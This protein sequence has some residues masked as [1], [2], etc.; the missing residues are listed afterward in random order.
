MHLK[1]Y[2]QNFEDSLS[3]GKSGNLMV[4]HGLADSFVNKIPFLFDYLSD[5]EKTRAERFRLYSDYN[6]Y[7]SVH[8][9]LRIELSK[10]LGVKARSLKILL[11]DIGKPYMADSNI[12]FNLSRTKN[13]FAFAIG[14]DNHFLGIDIE[15][16]KPEIDYKSIAINYFSVDEQKV[17]FSLKNASDQNRTFFEIWTRKEALLKAIGI[18]INGNLNKVHVMDGENVL[19]IFGKQICNHS[20][21]IDTVRKKEAIIS[22]ASS[23]DFIP[24]FKNLSFVIS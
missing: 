6:C 10:L 14:K 12:T 9:L 1:V 23:A 2:C 11:S 8:A 4:Y 22:I 19:D 18:G 24:E 21:K 20:F 3:Q 17:I 16:L 13:L 5:S 15:Q 7:V